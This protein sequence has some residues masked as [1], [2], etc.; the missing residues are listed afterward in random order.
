MKYLHRTY[1]PETAGTTSSATETP[2]NNSESSA[3]VET[4]SAVVAQTGSK[5]DILK[6]MIGKD[7]S[8]KQ[9]IANTTT[10]I[11]ELVHAKIKTTIPEKDQESLMSSLKWKLD[12]MAKISTWFRLQT[13][14]A[15]IMEK[16]WAVSDGTTTTKLQE[17]VQKADGLLSA[18]EG[19]GSLLSA[20]S[21]MMSQ[22]DSMG[23][24]LWEG[25]GDTTL[26][27]MTHAM[28]SVDSTLEQ[29]KN[30]AGA[31][32]AWF[33]A[34]VF[35]Q[36]NGLITTVLGGQAVAARG[37]TQSRWS[38]TAASSSTS[39]PNSS[40]GS[41]ESTSQ[42]IEHGYEDA[43][44]DMTEVDAKTKDEFEKMKASD[45]RILKDLRAIPK[46]KWN[47]SYCAQSARW[48]LED[49]FGVVPPVKTSA[50]LVKDAYTAM[51]TSER[52]KMHIASMVDA[53][54][55][56]HDELKGDVFE[57]FTHSNGHPTLG[58]AI[59][60]CRSYPSGKIYVA[61]WYVKWV[62]HDKM[63]PLEE[64]QEKVGKGMGRTILK[65]VWFDTKIQVADSEE[66]Y[67]ALKDKNSTPAQVA[68]TATDAAWKT[69]A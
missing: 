36:Y 18:A 61:E 24:M 32:P 46:Y 35:A 14:K 43:D 47:M 55:E 25:T 5:L 67:T 69:A 13:L 20:G 9:D 66:A 59:W 49:L 6:D 8:S 37:T 38:S 68:A 56:N 62:P 22:F 15:S 21:A 45:K 1:T 7:A 40:R 54:P 26:D 16:V 23:A 52:E 50:M 10:K 27:S 42:T 58:H 41:T 3:H 2:K 48:E 33:R 60:W 29:Y 30:T 4:Q 12:S 57:I 64:Y 11:L 53:Y 28:S 17:W 44:F 31:T 19:I 51:S 63:I 65:I 34:L 39:S